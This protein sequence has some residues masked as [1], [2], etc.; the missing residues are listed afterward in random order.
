MNP[1]HSAAGGF[2]AI[3][4][5]LLPWCS[6]RRSRK[7]LS[8]PC[9]SS[10]DEKAFCEERLQ[11]AIC[12]SPMP[13]HASQDE[14]QESQERAS[15][16][17]AI[18]LQDHRPPTHLDLH[19]IPSVHR[20]SEELREKLP[21]DT[22]LAT[23]CTPYIRLFTKPLECHFQRNAFISTRTRLNGTL[24]PQAHTF[25]ISNPIHGLD[26]F[27]GLSDSRSQFAFILHGQRLTHGSRR[28]RA[29]RQTHTADAENC[30][31]GDN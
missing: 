26:C 7:P 21:V 13:N 16:F 30:F 10:M 28:T 19:T 14:V 15:T 4:G 5:A 24:Q 17:A 3:T 29:S 2:H 27:F 11:G 8:N 18:C 25:F 12:R 6:P 22:S 9:R 1:H 23:S 20:W 31:H